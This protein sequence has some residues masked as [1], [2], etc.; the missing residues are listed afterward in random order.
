MADLI[1]ITGSID[2]GDERRFRD[3]ALQ[4]ERAM[5]ALHSPGGNV[6]AGIEIGKAVRL[7]EYIT[8]VSPDASCA[9]ACALIWLGGMKRFMAKGAQVG[10][11]AAYIEDN[12]GK[13][14]SG[15]ANALIGAYLNQLG[16]SQ[17]AIQYITFTPPD[18]IQWLTAADANKYGI[19]VATLDM[20]SRTPSSSV[21]EPQPEPRKGGDP[22]FQPPSSGTRPPVS[23]PEP[24]KRRT[25]V[26]CRP[27]KFSLQPAAP[28]LFIDQ[29]QIAEIPMETRLKINAPSSKTSL[30]LLIP[31]L[32]NNMQA[33]LSLSPESALDHV[34]AAVPN[35]RGKYLYPVTSQDFEERCGIYVERRLTLK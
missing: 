21:A 25:I 16:L 32:R 19:D 23:R 8:A 11:H 22:V 29:E 2:F 5:V 27:L 17:R 12:S 15:M 26:V 18:G 13:R 35:D 28:T 6:K 9:S 24:P 10:F 4:S 30:E 31:T 20:P 3:V 1:T 7:K 34:I 33:R 14:E